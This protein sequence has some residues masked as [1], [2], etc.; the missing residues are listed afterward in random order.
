MTGGL[1]E[2]HL[3]CCQAFTGSRLQPCHAMARVRGVVLC[4]FVERRRWAGH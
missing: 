4:Y 3:Q 2:Q 1:S